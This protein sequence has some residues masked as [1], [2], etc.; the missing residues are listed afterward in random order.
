[1]N[2]GF[3]SN[4]FT[5]AIYDVANGDLRALSLSLLYFI[6]VS[7]ILQTLLPLNAVASL[8]FIANAISA[9]VGPMSTVCY[10]YYTK[11]NTYMNIPMFLFGGLKFS[12]WFTYGLVEQA[13]PILFSQSFGLFIVANA[14]FLFFS[15]K[16]KHLLFT[17]PGNFPRDSVF[18]IIPRLVSAIYLA[19]SKLI[20]REIIFK[21]NIPSNKRTETGKESITGKK[22]VE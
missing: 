21:Q 5:L 16:S 12:I 13:F 7:L 11:D 17:F 18:L 14:F 20:G 2:E 9:G 6:T 4:L 3:I 19:G 10:L 8:A 15:N 22:K 1:M